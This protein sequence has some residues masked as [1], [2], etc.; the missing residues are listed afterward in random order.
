MKTHIVIAGGGTGGHVFPAIAVAQK[1][2]TLAPHTSVSFIGTARGLE[3][4]LV[5]EAGFALELVRVSGVKGKSLL[6]QVKAAVSLPMALLRCLSFLR[7]NQVNAVLGVGGYASAPALMAAFILRIPVAIC[8]QN[9]IPGLTNRLL[10]NIS[11][12]I[13]GTFPDDNHIFPVAKF[14]L[15]GNPLREGFEKRQGSEEVVPGRV[16]IIGGSLGASFLNQALPETA[17][18]LKNRGI[19][20]SIIHQSGRRDLE[21]VR[22]KYQEHNI[23]AQVLPFIDDMLKCYLSADI[24][25]CRSGATTCTELMALGLPSI[26]I[27]FPAAANDHQTKNATSMTV[28]NAAVLITQRDCTADILGKQLLKLLTDAEFRNKMADNAYAMRRGDAA[29]LIAE[30]ALQGF[31]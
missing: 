3:A 4:K 1:I 27:P 15:A 6:N 31:K 12:K 8:E 28:N 18:L 21:G 11:R 30:A 17:L 29:M 9:S 2:K 23:E 13:F 7:R 25:V 5:P 14:V 20:F 10:A 19:K 22:Q 24:V 16:V 26:M